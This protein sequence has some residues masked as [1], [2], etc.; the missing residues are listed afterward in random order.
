MA[1]T[2]L[3]SV[4][5]LWQSLPRCRI[6]CV[7]SSEHRIVTGTSEGSLI[8]WKPE[9]DSI[10]PL[11]YSVAS[12]LIVSVAIVLVQIE[13]QIE[14]CC[15]SISNQGEWILWDLTDGRCLLT[16]QGNPILR[17]LKCHS[18]QP[19]L[20]GF[21]D[22]KEIFVINAANLEIKFTLD[23]T[24]D[25]SWICDLDLTPSGINFLNY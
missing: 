6:T 15:V 16:K 1:S 9:N 20:I 4:I 19:Y 18:N 13:A 8:V 25:G 3:T 5:A 21:G 2:A 22:S 11:S 23:A 7:S 10:K 12:G 17:K 14:T 24:S